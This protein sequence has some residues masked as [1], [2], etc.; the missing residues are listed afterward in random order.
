MAGVA[1]QAGGQVRKVRAGLRLQRGAVEVEQDGVVERDRDAFGARLGVGDALDGGVFEL[2]VELFSL[3]VHLA[4]ND[5]PSGSAN[6]GADDGA[7]GRRARRAANHAADDG[8]GARADPSAA[9]RVAHVLTACLDEAEG[10]EES[11]R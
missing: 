8:T 10:K 11:Q 5:G 7:L 3:L 2:F 9:C 1:A 6:G 4:A